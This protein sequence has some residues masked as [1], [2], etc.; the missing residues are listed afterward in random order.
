MKNVYVAGVGMTPFGRHLGRSLESLVGA[1]V[2]ASVKDAG[3]LKSD[4]QAA[5]YTGS[6]QGHLHGQTLVPGQIVLA[7]NGVEGIAV[8]NVENACASGAS[9]FQLATHALQAGS[10]DVALVVG[11]EKMN[12]A[13]RKKMFSVFDGA[14]DVSSPDNN[15][16]ALLASSEGFVVP[17]GHESSRPYSVFMKVYAAFSRQHMNAYGTTQRQIAAISAKNHQHSVYNPLAQYREPYSIEQVLAAPPH[18]LPS[19]ASY[20]CTYFRWR[21]GRY[22]L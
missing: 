17:E 2:E 6:T 8:Y 9:G 7:K 15:L 21:C 19:D 12:V 4:L 1:A 5:F 11:A 20:V 10:C 18:Y 14:W 3:C 16:Q 13:D 22:R